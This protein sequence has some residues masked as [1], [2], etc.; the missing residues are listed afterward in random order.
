MGAAISGNDIRRMGRND[1]IAA[2]IK[3]ILWREIVESLRVFWM[4]A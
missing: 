4:R 1:D 3:A 2:A